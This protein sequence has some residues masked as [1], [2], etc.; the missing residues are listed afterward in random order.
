MNTNTTNS[1]IQNIIE[2]ETS[3]IQFAIYNFVSDF[4]LKQELKELTDFYDTDLG[5]YAGFEFNL[6]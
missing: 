5:Q 2:T 1:T 4:K 3:M 6:V